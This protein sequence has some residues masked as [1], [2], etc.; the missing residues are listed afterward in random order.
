MKISETPGTAPYLGP[1]WAAEGVG[2]ARRNLQGK[3][4]IGAGEG[5]EAAGPATSEF[6]GAATSLPSQGAERGARS[7]SARSLSLAGRAR[8]LRVSPPLPGWDRDVSGF[9]TV[10]AGKAEREVEAAE[11]A[12]PRRQGSG[13]MKNT[14]LQAQCS[15]VNLITPVLVGAAFLLCL[16]WGFFFFFPSN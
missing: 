2:I 5:A 14:L 15:H 8:H 9:G 7:V 4:N 6:T 11:A 12:R 1:P 16:V 13:L 10:G 3:E